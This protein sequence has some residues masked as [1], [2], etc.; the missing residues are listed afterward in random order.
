MPMNRIGM[1]WEEISPWTVVS[2]RTKLKDMKR[3]FTVRR[4]L[5]FLL[6]AAVFGIGPAHADLQAF[7]DS[8]E[9]EQEKGPDDRKSRSPTIPEHP[10]EEVEDEDARALSAFFQFLEVWIIHN[11]SRCYPEYPYSDVAN[12][13]DAVGSE[14]EWDIGDGKDLTLQSNRF[15]LQTFTG[16]SVEGDDLG[17]TTGFRFYGLMG[18]LG[19]D[20]EYRRWTD[21]SGSIDYLQIG[22]IIPLFQTNPATLEL[23]V[24]G[25]AYYD[26]IRV[27][28]L[29]LFGTLRSYPFFPIS[30]EL[31][32]G[33]VYAPELIFGVCGGRIG[34]HIHRFEIGADYYGLFHKDHVI[35]SVSVEAAVHF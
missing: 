11:A 25:A 30:L 4:I 21:R 28:G 34:V 12:A 27:N 2:R 10:D 16:L 22:W 15:T 6:V 8:V 1:S 31:R 32:G 18:V 7:G 14:D 13:P 5:A 17:W 19:P 24:G 29:T 26:L 3:A 20:L 35:H 9:E 23:T 33:G